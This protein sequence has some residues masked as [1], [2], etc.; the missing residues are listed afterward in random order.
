M[1]HK[2]TIKARAMA[3]LLLGEPPLAVAQSCRV[4]KSTVY[5][6]QAEAWELAR[7]SLSPEQRQELAVLRRMWP[8]LSQNGNSAW[9]IP[10]CNAKT[11]SGGLCQSPPVRGKR[12]CRMHGGRVVRGY[13]DFAPGR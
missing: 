1:A 5:R 4:P 12:R 10:R 7:K 2:L 6:W 9:G 3:D 13:A 8:G 11:R